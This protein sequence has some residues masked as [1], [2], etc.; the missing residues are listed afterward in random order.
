MP[1]PKVEVVRVYEHTDRRRGEHRVLVDRLWPRG[2]AKEAVDHAEWA[3]DVAPS[4]E[5]RRWYGHDTERFAEFSRRYRR[6]L[7]RAPAD[8]ALSRLRDIAAKRR[9]VLLTA[10]RD[11]EHSG[12]VVLQATLERRRR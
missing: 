10:T 1:P 9:L 2:L 5:L 8:Q 3:K 11:V 7:T 4:T 12:A 6:E